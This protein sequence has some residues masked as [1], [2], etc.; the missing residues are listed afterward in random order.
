MQNSLCNLQSAIL[1]GFGALRKGG[2]RLQDVPGMRPRGRFL[3]AHVGG[4]RQAD[5]QGALI[6]LVVRQLNPDR[7]PLDDLDEVARGVLRREQGERLTGPHGE[8]GDAALEFPPAAVH[9]YLEA[10]ALADAQV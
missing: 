1:L 6:W 5:E 9:V 2:I 8:T 3:E 7:Q 4:D 10:D